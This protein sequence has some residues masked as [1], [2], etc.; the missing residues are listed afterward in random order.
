M[1]GMTRV[2][3]LGVAQDAG[4]PHVGCS[5]PN[6]ERHRESPLYVASLGIVAD[7]GK[8]YLIDATPDLPHQIRMLPEFPSGI[9]LTHAH[10]GHYTGLMHLGREGMW[11][12]NVPVYATQKMRK[13]LRGNGPWEL[14]ERHRHVDYQALT[15]DKGSWEFE[16]A[17]SIEW[18]QVPH[19]NEY[20]DTV[21]FTIRAH[22]GKSLLFLPDID[23]WPRGEPA[24]LLEGCDIA[25][26]D[27][28]FFTR[29]ELGPRLFEVPHPPIRETLD[30]L[31]PEQAE[32][33]RFLHFNHT[34]P[35][36]DP[37]SGTRE[38][39]EAAGASIATQGDWIDLG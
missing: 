16:P 28:S 25:L 38:E 5:C 23:A 9:F 2:R 35:V 12:P 29:E 20:A 4:I 10:Y 1:S 6:C 18:V 14:L 19:R 32:K 36:L 33:V 39:I 17:L 11:T 21:A 24:S 13:F 34:N 37:E 31:K 22:H 3:I 27:G 26:I 30:R 8:T 7:S 15:G